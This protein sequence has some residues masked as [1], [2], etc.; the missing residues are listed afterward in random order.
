MR[1]FQSQFPKN[2]HFSNSNLKLS[3]QISWDHPKTWQALNRRNWE[4]KPP[5]RIFILVVEFKML[6]E[7]CLAM[8]GPVASRAAL[9]FLPCGAMH[10]S[11]ARNLLLNIFRRDVACSGSG[12][13]SRDGHRLSTFS[14]GARKEVLG[15]DWLTS[16]IKHQGE[17]VVWMSSHWW[18]FHLCGAE[19]WECQLQAPA[20]IYPE[21][22]PYS[23]DST[24]VWE[25]RTRD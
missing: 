2:C 5:A 20:V 12:E 6:G 7:S 24:F 4:Q 9:H 23:C 10:T 11:R 18:C 8:L 21:G 22:V 14:R 25:E 17:F 16:L 1:K 13:L 3:L 15:S 19:T